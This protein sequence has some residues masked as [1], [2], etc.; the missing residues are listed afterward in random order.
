MSGEL[1]KCWLAQ[2]SRCKK[3]QF[4]IGGKG[5]GGHAVAAAKVLRQAGWVKRKKDGW[6]CPACV[7]KESAT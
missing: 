3:D 7:Q 6:H 1:M 4:V 2:C 5:R